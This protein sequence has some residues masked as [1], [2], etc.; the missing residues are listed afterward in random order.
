VL[1]KYKQKA[2]FFVTAGKVGEKDMMSWKQIK[3]MKDAGMLIGS[4]SMT[5]ACPVHLKGVELEYEVVGSK[6]LLEEKLGERIEYFSSPTGY[7]NPEMIKI[8][9]SAGYK[10][11]LFSEPCLNRT[12]DGFVL[13]KTGIKSDYSFERFVGIVERSPL[14]FRELR[15]GHNVRKALRRILGY[16]GY[17]IVRAGMLG[18]K[19]K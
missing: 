6:N 9:K 11:M 10:H 15:L 12:G 1:E 5:H 3:E 19:N 4:H 2:A 18:M 16:R 7:V 13:S 17:E 14:V 8:A